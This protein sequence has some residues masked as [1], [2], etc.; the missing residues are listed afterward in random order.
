MRFWLV[1]ACG[2]VAVVQSAGAANIQEP[3]NA[4]VPAGGITQNR[5]EPV[6]SETWFEP[7]DLADLFGAHI[8][9]KT[10]YIA[11]NFNATSSSSGQLSTLSNWLF[12]PTVTWAAGDIVRFYTRTVEPNTVTFPDRLEVRF[13]TAGTST[14]VGSTATS[15]GDFGNLLLTINPDL[16]LAGYPTSWTPFVARLPSAGTGRIAFRH[17]VTDAGPSGS[18]SDHIGLDTFSLLPFVV[19]DVNGDGVVNNLDIAPF[20]LGLT[21]PSAFQAQ[22]PYVTLNIAGDVNNDGAVNNLDIAPFVALLTGGRPI[23]DA[24]EFQPLISLVPEPVSLGLLA[25]GGLALLRRRQQT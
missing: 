14:N 19:G 22:F 9:T 3:F 11:S 25:V 2:A 6:G 20:V 16:T 1:A 21:N 4:G 18:N 15:T 13:S 17:F 10:Q 24:P 23:G 12:T 8:G 7:E 5:S